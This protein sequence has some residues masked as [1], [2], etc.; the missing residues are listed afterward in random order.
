M[1]KFYFSCSSTLVVI[2]S[3][4]FL[5]DNNNNNTQNAAR[6]LKIVNS[7]SKLS[8]ERCHFKKNNI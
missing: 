2:E 7:N 6:G 8:T 3:C 1:V 4:F 5:F